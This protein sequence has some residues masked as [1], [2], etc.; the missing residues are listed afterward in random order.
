[1]TVDGGDQF[2]AVGE[3]GET[4]DGVSDRA[5]RYRLVVARDEGDGGIGN[6]RVLRVMDAGQGVDSA[7][8]GNAFGFTG[9]VVDQPAIGDINAARHRL[10]HRNGNY[11]AALR[12]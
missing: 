6:R 7:Q 2:L 9:T 4:G 11:L 8:I 1:M 3:T 10:R 5:G 12:R